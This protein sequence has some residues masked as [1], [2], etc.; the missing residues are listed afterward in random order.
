MFK[1]QLG[2]CLLLGLLFVAALVAVGLAI[3]IFGGIVMV[4][5]R[6]RDIAPFFHLLSNIV[7]TFVQLYLE[8]G[9]IRIFLKMARG[10]PWSVGEMFAGGPQ[11]LPFFG[12]SILFRLA[13]LAGLL[14]CIVPGI[15]IALIFS[16][17]AFL[18]LDRQT[19]VFE[20]F[21]VSRNLMVG[22]KATLFLIYL[23][24]FLLATAVTA[25]TCG[26]GYIAA[27]PFLVLMG[28]IVYLTLTGEPTVRPNRATSPFGTRAMRR[29]AVPASPAG[30]KDRRIVQGYSAAACH[31]CVSRATF[32]DLCPTASTA[33]T[34]VARQ[35]PRAD[36]CNSMAWAIACSASAI[37]PAR[38][39]IKLMA[40]K[41]NGSAG[42]NS[43]TFRA[44][45]TASS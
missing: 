6:N 29:A 25:C 43:Q 31:G 20:S 35:P 12:V 18:V 22:N 17:V 8:M 28:T 14:C 7:G 41:L 19:L 2:M 34:A 38:W 45:A 9:M 33:G 10:Q 1:D 23:V 30:V 21:G 13:V 40:M 32:G 3:G 16:Q 36:H 24:A 5:T 27:Y 37:R 44:W 26:I 4:V 15:I 42:S 11:L 39:Q